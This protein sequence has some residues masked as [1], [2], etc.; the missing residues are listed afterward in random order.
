MG[1]DDD[2]TEVWVE[3][4]VGLNAGTRLNDHWVISL[5]GD[6][7]GFGAGSDFAWHSMCVLAF[8]F[9]MGDAVSA[10]YLGY[11]AISQD[12]DQGGFEWDVL[13]HGPM[14]GV[15]IKF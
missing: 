9:D 8:T 15:A 14:I 10:G 5:R 11:R 3:P 6:V 13:A 2:Y 7:G 4:F 1:V 12:Y